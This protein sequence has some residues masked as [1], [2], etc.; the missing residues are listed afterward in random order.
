M[1]VRTAKAIVVS[2]SG[3]ALAGVMTLALAGAAGY[4][5]RVRASPPPW[6]NQDAEKHDV[7]DVRSV[8]LAAVRDL[9][10]KIT[11][12]QVYAAHD[13]CATAM[14]APDKQDL[15]VVYMREFS[16]LMDEYEQLSGRRLA[17]SCP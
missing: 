12:G 16:E 15:L 1:D 5:G 13:R 14:R 3:V 8:A 2:A 7:A 9:D 10:L 6:V 11:R 17:L 4:T